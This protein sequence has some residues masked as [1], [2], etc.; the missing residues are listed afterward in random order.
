MI[1]DPLGN[2]TAEGTEEECLVSAEINMA[3]VDS[4]RKDFSAL[5]DRV[6]T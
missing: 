5:H 3:S 6:F 1:V 2:V 4:V